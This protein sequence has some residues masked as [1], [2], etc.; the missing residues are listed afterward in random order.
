MEG[1]GFFWKLEG[2]SEIETQAAFFDHL[3]KS[4]HLKL[5][6]YKPQQLTREVQSRTQKI[7]NKKFEHVSFS[8][9]KI[10]AIIFS[11]CQFKN[12]QFIGSEI[13]NCEFH[14]CKFINTNTHKI[15]IRRTYVV[16]SSFKKCLNRRKHQN[17]GVHLYQ[18]LLNNSR[19]E[20]QVE[21][22]RDARFM[23]ERWKRYQDTYEFKKNWRSAEHYSDY[24]S[25]AQKGISVFQRFFWE[26]LFGCGIKIKNFLAT[27]SFSIVFFTFLNFVFRDEFGISLDGETINSLYQAFYYSTISLTTLGYGDITPTTDIGRVFAAVQSVVGFSLFAIFASMLFRRVAP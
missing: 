16:P 14:N 23:F 18:T 13:E 9:T 1:N 24:V 15:T 20:E 2:A 27:I 11:N 21:F 19:D 8:K 12:C 5:S 3:E 17:I 7:Q 10:S 6:I 22:E 26:K 4:D 25:V